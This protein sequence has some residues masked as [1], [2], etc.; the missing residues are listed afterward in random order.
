MSPAPC[1]ECDLAIIGAGLAG[2]AAALFAAQAGL[3]VVQAGGSGAIAYASG[4]FDLLGA[5]PPREEE[6]PAVRVDDPLAGLPALL[7]EHPGHPYRLTPPQDIRRAFARWLDFLAGCGLPHRL[8]SGRNLVLPSPVGALKHSFAAP[9]NTADFER[10]LAAGAP[11]LLADFF[12][13]NG[14]SAVQIAANLAPAW[15]GLRTV[16]LPFPGHPGGELY[17][18]NAARSLE[19]PRFREALAAALLP[20]LAGAACV[21]L[22]ALLGMHLP[23]AVRDDLAGRLGVAVFEVPTLPPSVPGIRLREALE[24]GLPGLGVVQFNQQTVRLV[25]LAPDGLELAVSGTPQ[26]RRVFCRGAVLATGRF[27]AGGLA[28]DLAGVRETVFGLPVAQPAAR[29]DWHRERYFDP[30]GHAVNSSGV[31][32][33]GAFRPLGDDGRVFHP[34]LYA[35]GSILAHADWM[36][37]KCGAGV[38]LATAQGAVEAFVASAG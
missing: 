7:A 4:Y 34:R 8:A 35:A 14:Y 22:P 25:R 31:E 15:P 5:I 33:D 16:R 3:S 24:E 26:E 19:L 9:E 23:A 18:E 30:R 12:G 38:A 1:L 11:C 20:H 32:V 17:A 13:L 6:R 21:G 2:A 27:L 36:R 37:M 10:L 29:R 28:A